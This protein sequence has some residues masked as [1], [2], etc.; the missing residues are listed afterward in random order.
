MQSFQMHSTSTPDC[1]STQP[2]LRH[3]AKHWTYFNQQP[4]PP[5]HMFPVKIKL[6]SLPTMPLMDHQ[7]F[8]KFKP[9]EKAIALKVYR[10]TMCTSPTVTQSNLVSTTVQDIGR[11]LANKRKK[12]RVESK[13]EQKRQRN[14]LDRKE[15]CS[16]GAGQ[17]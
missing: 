2:S 11:I 13:R 17:K 5:K 4:L 1:E 6:M 14:R 12:H 16:W 9:E 10:C 7:Q 15:L 8:Q 3:R